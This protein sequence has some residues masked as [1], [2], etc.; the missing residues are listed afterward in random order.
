MS[1]PE[2]I[3]GI[4]ATSATAKTYGHGKVRLEGQIAALTA[5]ENFKGGD[6]TAHP[7]NGLQAFGKVW[8]G[9][10]LSQEWW[11]REWWRDPAIPDRTFEQVMGRF[12][13]YFATAG[14]VNDL[15]L[16]MRTR[17]KHDVGVTPPFNDDVEAALS[18][19]KL[20]VVYTPSETDLYFPLTDARY[21]SAFLSDCSFVPVPS[22]WGH[23]GG[24]GSTPA[25]TKFLNDHIAPFME[26]GTRAQ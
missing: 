17:Q 22:L 10:L 8:T 19:V 1:H 4:V 21:E 12:V 11:R 24:V 23:I 2:F 13:T 3:D 18:A 16:Q 6:C 25:D 5:D 7:E 15:I 9:W 20:P 14:D 26:S